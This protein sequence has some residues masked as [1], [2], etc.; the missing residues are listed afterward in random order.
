MLKIPEHI[1]EKLG[2][3][4][5]EGIEQLN[6]KED[7]RL[8]IAHFG[9]ISVLVRVYSEM[10]GEPETRFTSFVISSLYS[11]FANIFRDK[12]DEWYELN[13]RAIEGIFPSFKT[14]LESLSS[15]LLAGDYEGTLEA[16]KIF[17]FA[18]WKHLAVLA[19]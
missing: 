1:A 5:S 12:S 2:T 8:V 17:F 6:R 9:Q 19:D 16:S 15:A 14:Y 4:T 3:H 7:I 10:S 11:Q 13:R 18:A